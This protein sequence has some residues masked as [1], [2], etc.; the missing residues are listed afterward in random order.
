MTVI[1]VASN[2]A[3]SIGQMIGRSF[4]KRSGLD[5]LGKAFKTPMVGPMENLRES[6]IASQ[7]FAFEGAGKAFE[8]S[9]YNLFKDATTIFKD[10]TKDLTL[11]KDLQVVRP[12]L[13]A[14]LN[15][16]VLDA[17]PDTDA[18]DSR[19]SVD[20]DVREETPTWVLKAKAFVVETLHKLVAAMVVEV[21]KEPAWEF[22]CFIWAWTCNIFLRVFTLVSD[23]LSQLND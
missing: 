4:V 8:S 7:K 16:P 14:D 1:N 13:F 10:A 15:L 2:P 18:L 5:Q 20:V 22:L 23:W 21:A 9:A 11:F 17:L 3:Q 12:D 19:P 6:L